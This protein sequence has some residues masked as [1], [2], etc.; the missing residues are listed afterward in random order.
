MYVYA[1]V[2]FPLP[3]VCNEMKVSTYFA[4]LSIF[5][6]GGTSLFWGFPLLSFPFS[7][8]RLKRT[9]QDLVEQGVVHLLILI[10]NRFS[11]DYKCSC[12]VLSFSRRGLEVGCVVETAR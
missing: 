10:L 12:P 6:G 3:T 7:F 4:A 8:P 1:F 11:N 5:N 2:C 9:S